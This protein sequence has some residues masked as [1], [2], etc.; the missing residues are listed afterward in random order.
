MDLYLLRH[1][2]AGSHLAHGDDSQRP[3]TADGIVRMQR[4]AT[5]LARWNTSIDTVLSSPFTR[6]RQ[7][8]E[9]AAAALNLPVVLDDRLEPG[10]NLSALAAIL[11]AYPDAKNLLLAGHEPDLSSVLAAVVG[12]GIYRFEKGGLVRVHLKTTAPPSGTLIWFLTPALMGA[13]A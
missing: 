8:A 5:T 12:G 9:I 2:E 1:G 4:Q 7:T 10:F 3:L 13:D 6:A 11:G